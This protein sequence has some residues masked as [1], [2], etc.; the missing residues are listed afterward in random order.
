MSE[1]GRVAGTL[2][3]LERLGVQLS[4]DDFGTGYSSLVLLQ[5]LPVSEI[6]IDRS[7]VK[8]LLTSPD[9]TKIVRSIVDLA[10]ALGI[11]AVAEG[12]ETE[13]IWDVLEALGCDSAQG[14]YVSRPLPA[15]RAT[16]WL[17]RHPS[18]AR[19]L[20]MLRGGAS[21][22]APAQPATGLA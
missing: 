15:E 6:K 10:H 21:A 13:E 1:P 11:E 14:W 8:R 22:D 2:A 16:E 4:L 7:F 18:R 3:A 9:D 5:R 19:S 12:V 20:R 17:F